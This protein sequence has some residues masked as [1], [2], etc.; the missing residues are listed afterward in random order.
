[1]RYSN[2]EVDLVHKFMFD[3]NAEQISELLTEH[4][5]RKRTADS[6][7]KK[8]D[9]KNREF[10]RKEM[11]RKYLENYAKNNPIKY[12]ARTLWTSAYYRAKKKGLEFNL[13]I[14]WIQ[15]RLQ[16]GICSVTGLPFEIKEYSKNGNLEKLSPYAPSLD[17][18]NSDKGYTEDNVQVVLNNYNKFKSDSRTEDSIIIA[19]AL[20]YRTKDLIISK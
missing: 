15:S 8:I 18:I 12:R 10:D 19:R 17:R 9:D 4:G 6:I 7:Q 14:E 11:R 5:Y 20:V 3:L 1:M 2:K 16:E 13:T